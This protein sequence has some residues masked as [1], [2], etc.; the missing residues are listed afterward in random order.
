MTRWLIKCS[1]CG[2]QR[3]LNVAFDLAS[4]GNKI[5]LYCSRCG[6]NM[7]YR[8]LGYVDEDDGIF[9]PFEKAVTARFKSVNVND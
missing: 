8:V 9:V 6:R 1:G 7:E 3:N 5:Y 4:I 2:T